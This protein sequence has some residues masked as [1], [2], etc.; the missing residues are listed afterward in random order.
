MVVLALIIVVVVVVVNKRHAQTTKGRYA[1]PSSL[2]TASFS[3]A[4]KHHVPD[5][6]ASVVS[7]EA[8]EVAKP[9]KVKKH[10][11]K[12]TSAKDRRSRKGK[13]SSASS[14]T[15]TWDPDPNSMTKDEWERALE[16]FFHK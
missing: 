13:R 15:G 9:A 10:K 14:A 4:S 11:T 7:T 12:P 5:R 8:Y 6:P 16:D 1:A 2:A 3:S